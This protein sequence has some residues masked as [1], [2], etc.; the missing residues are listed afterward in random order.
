MSHLKF[1]LNDEQVEPQG[2]T[3][4]VVAHQCQALYPQQWMNSVWGDVQRSKRN[5]GRSGKCAAFQHSTT[6]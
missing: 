3:V 5:G 2:P 4:D 6:Q 1:R